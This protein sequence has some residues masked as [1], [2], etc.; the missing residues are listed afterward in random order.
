M[1]TILFIH[2]FRFYFFM[3][4]HEPI[5]IHVAKGQ[6]EA[7]IILVPLIQ[8]SFN[9]GFKKNEMRIIIHLIIEHYETIIEA[10]HQTFDKSRND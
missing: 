4:E 5:H 10:W 3:N 8:I 2:G 6:N 9:K 1:P 7:R